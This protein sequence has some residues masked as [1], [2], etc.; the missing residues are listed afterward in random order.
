LALFGYLPDSPET[1]LLQNALLT[2]TGMACVRDTPFLLNFAKGL[3]RD[4]WPAFFRFRNERIEE[5]GPLSPPIDLMRDAKIEFGRKLP[6]HPAVLVVGSQLQALL[7]LLHNHVERQDAPTL[8]HR[9]Y[10]VASNPTEIAPILGYLDL[11]PLAD[12]YGLRIFLGDDALKR[13]FESI[14]ESS[15]EPVPTVG[16]G[17]DPSSRTQ[18]E[19]F[20]HDY[21]EQRITLVTQNTNR[22]T[23]ART[24]EALSALQGRLPRPARMLFLTTIHSDV[25]QYVCRDMAEGMREWGIEAHV[26]R[27]SRFDQLLTIRTVP[28]E[29]AKFD[30]DIVVLVDHFRPEHQDALPAGLPVVCWIQDELAHLIDRR[31]ISKLGSLDF[32]YALWPHWIP[33]FRG[34][35]YPHLEQLSFAASTSI[36]NAGTPAAGAEKDRALYFITNWS[37]VPPNTGHPALTEALLRRMTPELAVDLRDEVHRAILDDALR[38]LGV[39]L[40]DSHYRHVLL[41]VRDQLTRFYDRRHVARSLIATGMPVRLYGRGWDQVE[42]F[43]PYACGQVAQGEDLA[44]LYRKAAIVVQ[45]NHNGNAHSRVFEAIACGAAVLARKHP[46]DMGRWGLNEHL[47]IGEEVLTYFTQEELN[48]ATRRLLTDDEYYRGIVRNAQARVLRDHDYRARSRQMLDD[49]IR[50]LQ[51]RLETR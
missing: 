3:V 36:Y 48:A 18:L 38:G 43:K 26:V 9:I 42:E 1:K 39:Q 51:A 40:G 11:K 12:R 6:G 10:W 35:G 44:A 27:E 2:E 28:E 33:Y 5:L 34:L 22:Y 19:T 50:T 30:P 13:C 4:T 49:V 41:L 45:V 47:T 24:R 21:R 20:V 25:V 15:F 23:K 32:T 46:S 16:F 14:K 8:K 37:P 29:I 7:N 31:W 17:L